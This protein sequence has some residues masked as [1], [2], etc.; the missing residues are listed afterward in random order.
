MALPALGLN[1]LRRHWNILLVALGVWLQQGGQV[2]V[3][4]DCLVLLYGV[5]DLF[6]QHFVGRPQSIEEVWPVE[7]VRVTAHNPQERRQRPSRYASRAET[8]KLNG[9]VE[10]LIL[11]CVRSGLSLYVWLADQSIQQGKFQSKVAEWYHQ[12]HIPRVSSRPASL[13][14]TCSVEILEEKTTKRESEKKK[15]NNQN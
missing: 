4:F 11:S 7:L 6:L 1:G 12:G 2:P 3:L 15:K 13:K 10:V 5:L 8:K 14:P 9:R